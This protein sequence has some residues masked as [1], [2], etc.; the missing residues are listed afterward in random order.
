MHA[1]FFSLYRQALQQQLDDR[2]KEVEAARARTAELEQEL[3]VVRNA[4]SAQRAQ[5]ANKGMHDGMME[6]NPSTLNN[7]KKTC[8]EANRGIMM[9]ELDTAR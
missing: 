3:L 2:Q 9:M 7:N 8:I 4:V 5:V 6:A 1:F